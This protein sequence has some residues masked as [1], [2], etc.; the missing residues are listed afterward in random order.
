MASNLLSTGRKNGGR[1]GDRKRGREHV[2]TEWVKDECVPKKG[3]CGKGRQT[4]TRQ[5][6]NCAV[7]ERQFRCDVPCDETPVPERRSQP[8]IVFPSNI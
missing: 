2:C 4:G 6:E 8:Q 3:V 5:G 7:K 1:G